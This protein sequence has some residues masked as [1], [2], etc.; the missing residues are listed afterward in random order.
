MAKILNLKVKI[1]NG[2]YRSF[3]SNYFVLAPTSLEIKDEEGKII[4]ELE[5]FND[6]D[7]FKVSDIKRLRINF[8]TLSIPIAWLWQNR[9]AGEIEFTLEKLR[10]QAFKIVGSAL[11][12][13]NDTI[14]LSADDFATESFEIYGNKILNT[15][16][17]ISLNAGP[18]I[19][20][21]FQE[22]RDLIWE[23]EKAADEASITRFI[24]EIEK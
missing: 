2:G 5:N 14:I 9:G 3:N 18:A 16:Q 24:P 10:N 15:R 4:A 22:F 19:R 6:F 1:N 11:D 12:R 20:D 7:P 21:T 23:I 8:E 13:P 17:I